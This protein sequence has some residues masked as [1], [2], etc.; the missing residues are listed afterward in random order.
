MKQEMCAGMQH[1][2]RKRCCPVATLVI[3]TLAPLIPR[4]EV[5]PDNQHWPPKFPTGSNLDSFRNKS[6][7]P[8]P[9]STVWI[10]VPD[11]LMSDWVRTPEQTLTANGDGSWPLDIERIDFVAADIVG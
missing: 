6:R 9:Q 10:A 3:V 2:D 7:G 4:R 5:W 1:G 8:A 11:R